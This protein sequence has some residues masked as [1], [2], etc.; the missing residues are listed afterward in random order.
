M[1]EGSIPSR[2]LSSL[3]VCWYKS[4]KMHG[5]SYTVKPSWSARPLLWV[6]Y[7]QTSFK[8]FLNVCHFDYTAVAGSGKVGPV[9][10]VNHTSWVAVV[11]LTDRPKSVRNSCVIE[12]FCGV[13]CVVTL[14]FR[15]FCWCM[16]FCYRT[17]SDPFLFLMEYF[18]TNN[19]YIVEPAFVF[20]MYLFSFIAGC[21]YWK[22]QCRQDMPHQTLLWKQGTYQIKD[23][24]MGKTHSDA[25]KT[26]ANVDTCNKTN[27][28]VVKANAKVGKINTNIGEQTQNWARQT[29]ILAGPF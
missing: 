26:N 17:E 12:L 13:V 6:K 18:E 21:G 29:L 1:L 28:D 27:S 4:H 15:H 19:W 5:R 10:Q 25:G 22:R 7:T 3:T 14:P 20:Y 24:N 11:I 23:A 8:T 16:G 9:N 2:I